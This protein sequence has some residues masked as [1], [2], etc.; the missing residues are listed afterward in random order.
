MENKTLMHTKGA[1]G[2]LKQGEHGFRM[3]ILLHSI[4]MMNKHG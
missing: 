3:G 4:A 2:H 1:Y